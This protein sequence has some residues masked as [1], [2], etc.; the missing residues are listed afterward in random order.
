MSV[1]H[2]CGRRFDA[3]PTDDVPGATECPD[4]GAH[5]NYVQLRPAHP[6]PCGRERT[7]PPA[8]DCTRPYL[9]AEPTA[10]VI[11]MT[12]GDHAEAAARA[13]DKLRAQLGRPLTL[14]ERVNPGYVQL[15]A[16]LEDMDGA[17]YD[18]AADYDSVR[19]GPLLLSRQHMPSFIAAVLEAAWQAG[20]NQRKMAEGDQ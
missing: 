8:P 12:A 11:D 4:P 2:I 6:N 15:I 5:R 9:H 20:S 13:R 1:S 3:G 19:V 18:I 16:R 7:E 10:I 17:E 14:A